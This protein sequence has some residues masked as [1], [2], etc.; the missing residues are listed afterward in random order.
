MAAPTGSVSL[1]SQKITSLGT[2]TTSTDAAT[3]GYIDTEITNLINGAPGTLDTLKEIADQIQAGGTFYDSVLFKS[4]GTMTGNLTLAGAP[5]QNLHAATKLYDLHLAIAVL[6]YFLRSVPDS[7]I[8]SSYIGG[9]GSRKNRNFFGILSDPNC[10]LFTN[11][12]G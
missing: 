8:G 9:E 6:I 10:V 5:T 4:G 2:P 1:N 7:S 3:K 12:F 11:L